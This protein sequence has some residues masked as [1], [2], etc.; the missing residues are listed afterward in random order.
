M[1][2]LREQIFKIAGQRFDLDSPEALASVLSTV[3]KSH[4]SARP[5]THAEAALPPFTLQKTKERLADPLEKLKGAHPIIEPL[6]E[7]RRRQV[8][9][10]RFATK[11]LYD[12]VRQKRR[13]LPITKLVAR[14]KS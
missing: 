7:Y 12:E 2:A 13:S 1:T 8:S 11:E 10:P 6:L 3:L 5:P 4:K 14:L 9:T